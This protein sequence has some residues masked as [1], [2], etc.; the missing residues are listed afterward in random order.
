M[1][2]EFCELLALYFHQLRRKEGR[3]IYL[4][5]DV[6]LVAEGA[7]DVLGAQVFGAFLGDLN[8]RKKNNTKI[9]YLEGVLMCSFYG[10]R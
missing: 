6:D 4:H 1:S 5:L 10:V 9:K 2:A 3:E 8:V 7:R